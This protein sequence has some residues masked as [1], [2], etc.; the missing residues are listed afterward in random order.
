M[1]GLVL[2][3]IG[4]TTNVESSSAEG[5]WVAKSD[6][7]ADTSHEIIACDD[8][9]VCS[10]YSLLSATEDLFL[11]QPGVL[12]VVSREHPFFRFRSPQVD[13]PPPRTDA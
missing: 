5:H 11:D 1:V 8:S 3:L 4:A 7:P 2:G 12:Q 10:P 9:I 6:H 13:L